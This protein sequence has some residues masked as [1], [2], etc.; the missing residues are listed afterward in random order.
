MPYLIRI[1]FLD[2]N[3]SLFLMYCITVQVLLIFMPYHMLLLE[4]MLKK[5]I[6]IL[7]S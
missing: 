6:L 3:N 1:T 4:K 5:E 2:L 7:K